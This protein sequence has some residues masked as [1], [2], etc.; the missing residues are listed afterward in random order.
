MG[1]R[2]DSL[3]RGARRAADRLPPLYLQGS[4]TGSRPRDALQES[5]GESPQNQP[6][7]LNFPLLVTRATHAGPLKPA[8]L[9]KK[10]KFGYNAVIPWRHFPLGKPRQFSGTGPFQYCG[11]ELKI[12]QLISNFSFRLHAK[13]FKIRLAHSYD[14]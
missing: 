2:R 11:V 14:H 5:R 10:G 6:P 8:A 7:T 1:P 9:R 13:T 3:T 4:G 12:H